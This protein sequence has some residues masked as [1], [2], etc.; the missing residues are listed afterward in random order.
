MIT[1]YVISK[2]TDNFLC[3]EE[4]FISPDK[5]EAKKKFEAIK[6]ELAEE[7]RKEDT[8]KSAEVTWDDDYLWDG[9]KTE[10]ILYPAEIDSSSWIIKVDESISEDEPIPFKLNWDVELH[11]AL[12]DFA[13]ETGAAHQRGS[14]DF[15]DSRQLVM[16]LIAAAKQFHEDH[17]HT[18]WEEADYLLTVDE[19]IGEFLG[20]RETVYEVES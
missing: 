17:V 2:V 7:L 13:F 18:N 3:R 6:I 16:D 15:E 14:V 19:A 9:H 8:L 5:R 20:Q 11:E 10:W 1:V 4:V 12:V